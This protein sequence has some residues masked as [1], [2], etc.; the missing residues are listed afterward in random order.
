VLLLAYRIRFA[1]PAGKL[2]IEFIK[3]VDP[4]RVQVISG[5]ESLKPL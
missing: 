5:R 1:N 4:K 2:I 3:T